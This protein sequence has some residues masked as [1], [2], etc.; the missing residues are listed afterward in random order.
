M[1]FTDDAGISRFSFYEYNTVRPQY[2]TQLEASYFRGRHEVKAGF[3]HRTADVTSA[4]VVPGN[5]VMAIHDG[6]PN[7]IAWVTAWNQFTGATGRYSNAYLSDAIS[8]DRLTINIGARWDR[9][10]SSVQAY[11][12]NGNPLLSDLLP[13]LTGQAADDAIVWNSISPRIGVSYALT[14]DRGTI[15]RASY[16]AF[17]QQ[18][19]AGQASFFST[20]GA[21]RAVYFYNVTDLNGN[22]TV[23]AAEIAGRTCTVA[24]AN[25]GQCAWAGFNI[26][27]PANVSAPN[28]RIGDYS[29]PMTHEVV[30]GLDHELMANFGVSGNVTWRRFVDFNW[31]PVQ[32]LR[33]DDY[34]QLGTLTGTH[35]AIGSF[36]TPY[37]GVAADRIPANRTATEYVDRPDYHQRFLGFE[38]AA[39]KRLSNRW[40]ARLGFS[41]NDHREYIGSDQAYVDP[42][43]SPASPNIDGGQVMRQTAGSGKAGI[44][45]LLPKYQFIATGMY[46]AP[47]GINVAGNMVTRQG[48]SMPY[49]RSGVVTGDPLVAQKNVMAVDAVDDFRL[50]AVTSLDLRIGKEFTFGV[51]S[52]RP[53]VAVD[54]DLFNALNAS[55][56]LGRQYDLRL[57]TADNVLEIMNPRILRLGARI[58]F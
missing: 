41:T 8:M 32:G 1:I 51:G 55:T 45:Q 35:P 40:M 21:R 16:A 50:P 15:A 20:V 29:T 12:Q 23:E 43:S 33:G 19:N 36:E 49:Y 9:Q 46:Q 34:V 13:N 26:A 3:G 42:T 17:A 2:N 53:R 44:Y 10:S 56:V 24:L 38:L 39:T 28:H 30:L 11:S 25:A 57:N 47:W 37:Y 14:E 4:Y 54:L 52:Y 5:A 6:Y 31:R 27:N 22:G 48:F 7:M 18:M 58:N